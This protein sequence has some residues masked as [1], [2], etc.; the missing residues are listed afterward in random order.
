VVAS[1]DNY[2]IGLLITAHRSFRP[3]IVEL[4]QN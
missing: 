2:F 4:E 3:E 1:T